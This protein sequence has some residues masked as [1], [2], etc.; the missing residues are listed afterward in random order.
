MYSIQ[1]KLEEAEGPMREALDIFKKILGEEH[2]NVAV[3]L[4]NIAVLL[5]DQVRLAGFCC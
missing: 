4:N 1:G 3:L 2:P 5:I